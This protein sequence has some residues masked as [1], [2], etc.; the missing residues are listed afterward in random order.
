MSKLPQQIKNQ[1]KGLKNINRDSEW[2][3][4]QRQ[5]LLS[6][7]GFQ[8]NIVKKEFFVKE[9]FSIYLKQW[10]SSMTWR[11]IGAM[12]LLFGVVIGPGIATVN[13]SRGSLPGDTLYPVKRG[14]EKAKISVQFSEKAKAQL[15]INHVENRVNELARLTKEQAPSPQRKEKVDL[16]LIELK[17][18]VNSVNGRIE[19]L[20]EDSEKDPKND[21]KKNKDAAKVAILVQEKTVTVQN[22]IKLT[23]ND[24]A[25]EG[26]KEGKAG[27]KLALESVNDVAINALGL[28]VDT[29]EDG[30]TSISEED[31]KKL[32]T[33]QLEDT[34]ELVQALQG[35]LS[36]NEA[37]EDSTKENQESVELVD[38]KKVS[39]DS[40]E[41]TITEQTAEEKEADLANEKVNQDLTDDIA[42]IKQLIEMDNLSQAVDKLAQTKIQVSEINKVLVEDA[43]I[44][45]EI[46][47]AEA[48][49]INVAEVIKPAEE[50]TSEVEGDVTDSTNSDAEKTLID[51]VPLE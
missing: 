36:G 27:V 41:V 49:K 30:D 8:N 33:K 37:K 15:E 1:L 5:S 35:E 26:D 24:L 44:K 23:V 31:V 32:V 48:Q 13:A 14:I 47:N 10:T 43:R 45:Q 51:V 25:T 46:E 16:A 4:R 42:I 7:I 6:E 29:H 50:N 3:E 18:D 22:S 19:K 11:S 21:T 9:L 40:K 17:K 38:T 2:K 28:I 12:F 34:Q 39:E 20:K